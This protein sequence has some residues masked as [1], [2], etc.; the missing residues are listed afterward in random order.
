MGDYNHPGTMPRLM[1]WAQHPFSSDMSA[2][3]WALF[4]GLILVAV[5]LW[6]RVLSFITK[7]L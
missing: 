5:F 6:T 7:E 1:A 4:M 2:I 3:D